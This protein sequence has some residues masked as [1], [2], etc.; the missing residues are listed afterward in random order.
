M[1]R[2]LDPLRTKETL[3]LVEKLTDWELFQSLASELISSNILIYS[4]NET[5]KAARDF[6]A[7]IASSYRPSTRKRNIL[8]R[9]Y[10]NAW[11][12]A[13]IEI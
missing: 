3:D 5:D 8:D 2:N 10:V 9:K 11:S 12:A 7:S 1:L 6:A 4:S 13:F